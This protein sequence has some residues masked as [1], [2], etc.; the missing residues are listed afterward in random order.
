M[1]TQSTHEMAG[2]ADAFGNFDRHKESDERFA[3]PSLQNA[4]SLRSA[5]ALV[6][7]DKV[8]ACLQLLRRDGRRHGHRAAARKSAPLP[9]GL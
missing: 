8:R 6:M 3:Q 1:A 2:T 5:M 4:S 9:P 7:T